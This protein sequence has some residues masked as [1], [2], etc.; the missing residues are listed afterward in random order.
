MSGFQISPFGIV[1]IALY[2]FAI[3]TAALVLSSLLKNLRWRWWVLA[4]PALLL[5]ALP[6]A[7]EAWIAWHF[8][9]ACKDAGVKV[10]K[11]VEVEGF[12]DSIMQSGYELVRDKGYRFM[13]HPSDNGKTVDQIK[14]VQ[15][16]WQKT[17]LDHPQARYQYKYSYQTTPHRY[18]EPIGWKLEKLEYQVIDRET[19][20]VLGRDTRITRLPNYM[21]LLWLRFFGPANLGC[22]GPLNQPE[23]QKRA[24]LIY[25]Y[26]LIPKKSQ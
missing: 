12:Y 1:I 20:E 17:P 4:P 21:E 11:Q 9:E 18:E 3:G 14:F 26:V 24:G 7:E 23:R 13:E 10:Y 15:G 19:G 8:K 25:E 6:W 16:E 5:M 2:S 22:S